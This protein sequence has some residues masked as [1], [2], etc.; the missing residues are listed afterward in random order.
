MN[1]REG[2]PNP[3][4]TAD[5][6]RVSP[7]SVAS[8]RAAKAYEKAFLESANS[9]EG[10]LRLL[11]ERMKRPPPLVTTTMT[12]A[13]ASGNRTTSTSHGSDLDDD[14]DDEQKN[15]GVLYSHPVKK[16]KRASGGG[17]GFDN[18]SPEIL[19]TS[20]ASKMLPPPGAGT[21]HTAN[22][23]EAYFPVT[24]TRNEIPQESPA[25]PTSLF[26]TPSAGGGRKENIHPPR[27]GSIGSRGVG[28]R[29][30][31][32]LAAA[33]DAVRQ[34]AK[35]DADGYALRTKQ[36]TLDLERVTEK[37]ESLTADLTE[38]SVKEQRAKEA[39]A[40]KLDGVKKMA[41]RL[42]QFERA[43]ARREMTEV[44]SRLGSVSV[45]RAG[46]ALQEVW[47]DGEA[48]S[49]LDKRTRQLVLAKE[50][51][52]DQRKAV[53]KLLPPPGAEANE[54]TDTIRAEYV[55]SE[56]IHKTRVSSLKKE[57]D[58]I[59]RERESL[60]REKQAYIRILK[61]T[62]DEDASRF[63]QHPLLGNRYVLMNML[64]RGGFSEVYKAFDVVEMREVACK[65]HQLSPQWNEQRKQTYVRH[66]Q[67]E[68]MIHK[69]LRHQNVVEMID[70]FEGT[71][72]RVSRIGDTLFYL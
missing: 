59:A 36:L 5:P 28:N 56:E 34:S 21:H 30:E 6:E 9:N 3:M 24:E 49:E 31:H 13:V 47:E 66:A 70:V 19:K 7:T 25:A 2:F 8:D 46:A 33:L 54:Q 51:S 4:M 1:S 32:E 62:R 23:I 45:Q 11:E 38:A 10:K 12:D 65:L 35:K 64:G 61:R 15:F 52:D 37:V 50:A 41:V 48:F 71:A 55:L 26:A 16:Q 29:T 18:K 63:N 44:G 20:S 68:C 40:Q 53:K 27:S 22:H 42:A 67:R 39:E 17:G 58:C 57:E 43:E 14:D 72:L 60:E 69:R